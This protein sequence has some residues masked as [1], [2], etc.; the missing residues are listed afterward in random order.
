MHLQ[1]LKYPINLAQYL[2]YRRSICCSIT[3]IIQ[4]EILHDLVLNMLYVVTMCGEA[5]SNQ[6]VEICL[7]SLK[8]EGS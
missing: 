3:L 7:G 8:C 1:N 6:E 4:R 2:P 5:L